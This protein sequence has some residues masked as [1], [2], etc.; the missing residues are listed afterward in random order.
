MTRHV[1]VIHR[2]ALT[3]SYCRQAKYSPPGKRTDP[4]LY[5]SSVTSSTNQRRQVLKKYG[6]LLDVSIRRWQ[7]EYLLIFYTGHTREPGDR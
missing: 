2:H 7:L 6:R 1:N 4:Q 3:T 5:S